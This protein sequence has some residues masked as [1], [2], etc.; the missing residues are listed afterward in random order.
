MI[1]ERIKRPMRNEKS[2][3]SYFIEKMMELQTIDDADALLTEILQW[4]KMLYYDYFETQSEL[5]LRQIEPMSDKEVKEFLAKKVM[6]Y[7]TGDD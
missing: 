2:A 1:T 6:M 5:F 3:H 7:K 4:S